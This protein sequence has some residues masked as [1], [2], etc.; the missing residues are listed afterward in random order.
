MPEFPPALRAE[1]ERELEENPFGKG[2]LPRAALW[3]W[4]EFIWQRGRARGFFCGIEIGVHG[5]AS[6]IP[7]ALVLRALARAA[8]EDGRTASRFMIYGI[9]PWRPSA[10]LANSHNPVNDAWWADMKLHGEVLKSV[11]RLLG[12]HQLLEQVTLLQVES[13]R[14]ARFFD[15]ESIDGLVIDGNHSAEGMREDVRLYLPRVR[16]GGRILAD[17]LNWSTG[18]AFTAAE[19]RDEI[20]AACV[21]IDV[22]EG[23]AGIFEK[24]A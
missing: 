13:A 8:G 9:D 10:C 18:G 23:K 3:D 6:L 11:V 2:W 17:D 21:E 19:A 4:L 14:A 24:R 5:G 7:Q 15:A 20:E 12:R 22:F 16:A 1:V